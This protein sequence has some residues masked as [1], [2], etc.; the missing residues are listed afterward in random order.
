MVRLIAAIPPPRFHMFRYFGLLSSHS[1]LRTEVVPHPPPDPRASRPPP[2][3]GDQ[4][5]LPGNA[6]ADD[7]GYN[8]NAPCRKRWAWLLGHVFRADLENCPRCG[9]PMRWLEAVATREAA[10]RLLAKL[11]L[12]P[13]P[14]PAAPAPSPRRRVLSARTPTRAARRSPAATR[15]IPA[16]ADSAGRLFADPPPLLRAAAA[17]ARAALRPPEWSHR[18]PSQEALAEGPHAPGDDTARV[19]GTARRA[20]PSATQPTDPLPRGIRAALS[21]SEASG[22]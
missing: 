13:Q 11:G 16:S 3:A 20:D 2:A 10:A 8:D 17:L 22:S 19:H 14:P 6:E 12:A 15:A 21:G 1:S 18:V 9:G 4:L 7:A 5:K